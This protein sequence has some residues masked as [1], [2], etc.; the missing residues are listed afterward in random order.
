[1]LSRGELSTGMMCVICGSIW[2]IWLTSR[3]NPDIRNPHVSSMRKRRLNTRATT[4]T[5]HATKSIVS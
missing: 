2:L 3:K 1:M 5:I 4:C